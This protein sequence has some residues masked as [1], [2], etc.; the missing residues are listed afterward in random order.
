M[1]IYMY[2]IL[3]VFGGLWDLI[4]LFVIV[5]V[6]LGGRLGRW[7]GKCLEGW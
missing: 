4:F 5:L 6:N 2:F 3:S 7:R 1:V